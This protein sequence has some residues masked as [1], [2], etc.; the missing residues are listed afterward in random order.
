M[1]GLE[2]NRRTIA[3]GR[4]HS[5]PVIEYFNVLK[6]VTPRLVAGAIITMMN[7]FV[8]SREKKLSMGALS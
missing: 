5:L 3:Q 8:L 7:Q 2:F 1:Q 6:D 4:M